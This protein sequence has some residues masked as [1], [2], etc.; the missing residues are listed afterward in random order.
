MTNSS[1]S[2][3]TFLILN[4]KVPHLRKP[5]RPGEPGMVGY[6]RCTNYEENLMVFWRG[7]IV[8]SLEDLEGIQSV[9][10]CE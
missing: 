10:N 2:P 8:I 5:G 9:E 7:I 4:L 6:P 1:G 3:R